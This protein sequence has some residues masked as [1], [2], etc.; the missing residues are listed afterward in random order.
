MT[1]TTAEAAPARRL[2]LRLGLG[3][4]GL[5][6]RGRGGL[7]LLRA[8]RLLAGLARD[9]AVGLQDG[10]IDLVRDGLG[11][12]LLGRGRRRRLLLR[13]G[14]LRHASRGDLLRARLGRVGL[15]RRLLRAGLLGARLLDRGHL[16]DL[17]E[18]ARLRV[19]GVCASRGHCERGEFGRGNV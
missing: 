13:R 9:G 17:R 16:L 19:A 18:H 3:C 12:A 6:S 4:R 1:T 15:G 10:A 11:R 8:S 14:R 5:L 2:R 7:L